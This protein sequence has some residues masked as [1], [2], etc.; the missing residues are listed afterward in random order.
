MSDIPCYKDVLIVAADWSYLA[1]GGANVVFKYI[2]SGRPLQNMVLRT[3]KAVKEHFTIKEQHEWLRKD[4]LPVVPSLEC[5][6]LPSHLV[7]VMDEQYLKLNNHLKHADRPQKHSNVGLD[8]SQRSALLLPRLSSTQDRL[9]LE[10]KPK[11]LLQSPCA[12]AHATTCRTCAIR[13]M[14]ARDP[15][16]SGYCPLDLLSQDPDQCKRAVLALRSQYGWI[17]SE[18]EVNS[19][20][21]FLSDDTL[22]HCLS[23]AQFKTQDRL[24]MCMTLRDCSIY[25]ALNRRTFEVDAYIADLDRKH[26]TK[27][28]VWQEIEQ[29]L[30][31]GGWYF[32]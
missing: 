4:L 11:W 28:Q 29:Q 26:P 18:A 10:F 23:E 9:V 27:E 2:G 32:T 30:L 24:P 5:Y 14:R 6:I 3:Q 1:E 12:P 8:M 7:A 16:L 19:V 17:C 31:E 25:L 20:V 21:A 13:R 22:I 15:S